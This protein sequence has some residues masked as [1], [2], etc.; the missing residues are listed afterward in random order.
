MALGAMSTSFFSTFGATGA[1]LGTTGAAFGLTGAALG[2]AA[3]GCWKK[4]NGAASF[5]ATG[6]FF[7]TGATGSFL[8]TGATGAFFS[9]GLDFVAGCWK[10][11]KGDAALVSTFFGGSTLG[12]STFFGGST[13]G[14]SIFSTFFATGLG[15]VVAGAPPKNDPNIFP[16]FAGAALTTGSSSSGSLATGCTG[17]CAT[18]LLD[19]GFLL[20]SAS[21]V[22]E[23]LGGGGT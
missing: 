1:A 15:F 8:A 21:F 12:G 22:T 3:A 10:N 4:A 16:A 20:I 7:A 23:K 9:T 19:L 2:F 13:F 5:L 11:A 6:S 18:G 14:G 17:V